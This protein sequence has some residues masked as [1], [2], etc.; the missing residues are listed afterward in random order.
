MFPWHALK[1]PSHNHAVSMTDT[2]FDK[3]ESGDALAASRLM[4]RVERGSQGSQPRRIDSIVVG[5]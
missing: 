4:T 5:Q 2:I 1:A 3:F